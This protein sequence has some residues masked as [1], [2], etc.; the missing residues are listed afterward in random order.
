LAGSLSLGDSV[1]ILEGVP[2]GE[3]AR[4]YRESIALVYPSACEGLGLPAA[5]A[6]LTGLPSIVPADSPMGSLVGTGG[7][8]VALLTQELLAEVML[9]LATR[10]D[11]WNRCVGGTAEAASRISWELTSDSLGRALELWT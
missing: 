8:K 10:K 11:T 3:L 7:L 4:L 5:E 9:E 6:L 2:D 1:R